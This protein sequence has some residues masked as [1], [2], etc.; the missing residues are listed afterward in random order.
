[1]A[2]CVKRITD[3]FDP[4]RCQGRRGA[5][6][7]Q[8]QAIAEPGSK[9]CRMCGNGRPAAEE[10]RKVTNYLLTKFH[11]S[12]QSKSTSPEITSLREEIGILRLLIET[13]INACNTPTDLILQSSTISDLVSKVERVV[14]SCHKL[15]TNLGSYMDKAQLLDFASKVVNIIGECVGDPEVV[16]EISDQILALL[17]GDTE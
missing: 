6:G 1:M 14:V 9:Y 17:G 12:V 3:P 11:A 13:K 5:G 4:N 8:C 16:G 2:D 10:K 15:E 7:N